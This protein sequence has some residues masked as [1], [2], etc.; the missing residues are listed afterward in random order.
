MSHENKAHYQ[1]EKEAIYLILI[2]IGDEIYSTVDACKTAQEMWKAIERLQQGN[3]VI[4]LRNV[5]CTQEEGIDYDEV[6][7][8]VARIKA[9]RLFLAYVSFMGF[10]V[11]QMDVKSAFLYGRIEE[12]VYVCQPLGFEDPD[13]PDKVYK[14]EKALYGKIDQT[15]FIKRQKEDILLVQVYV[16]D[17]IFGSTKKELCIEFEKL[18][19]DKF[20]MSSIGELTFFLRLQVKQESNGI[21]ISQDKYID[22]IL[23]KFKYTNVKPVSTLMDKEKALLKDSDG[24]DV[25]VHLYRR[26][27]TNMVEFDIGQEDDKVCSTQMVSFLKK[28]QGS[29]DFHQIVDFLKASHIRILDNEEIELNATVDGQAKTITKSSVKRHLKLADA[30]GISTL[31]TTEIFKQLALMGS[32][33]DPTLLNNSEMAA[34]EPGDLPVPDLRTIE[35]LCQPSLNGQGGTFMKRRLEECYDLIENMTAHHNDWD[36][37]AQRK[38]NINL[39]R[40]LQVNQQVKAITPNCKTFGGPHS[41]FDCPATVGNTQNVY[42]AGA[43][44][45]VTTN[46]FIN[47]MKANDAILKNMQT[48]MT[49]LKNSN[50]KLKNMFDQFMKMNTASSLGSGTLPGNTITNPKEDLKGI[51]TRSETAYQGPTTPTTTYFLVV[52]RETK[53]TK[54]TV[55]PTNNESTEDVQPS[56][57]PTESPILISEP[58]TSLIIEPVASP[59]S[60]LKHNLRPSIPYPSRLQD[61]KLYDKANDQREKFFQIFK[62]LNFNISFAGALILMP[63]FG[64]SIKSLLTNKD[65]LSLADL[66]ASINLMPFSIWNK[67]S[68]SDLSLTC[69]TLELTD[70]SISHPV[71]VFEDVFVK[72][73]LFVRPKGALIDVFKGELTLRVGKEAITFNLDQTSRYS[74]NYNNMTTNRIDVIDMACEE[75]SQEVLDFSDVIASGNPTPYY[76]SIVSTTSLTLTSFGNSD[77][78]LEEVD[79]FLAL[80]DDPTSPKVDQSYLDSE[81]DILNLEAFLNDDP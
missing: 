10:L 48:N 29:E 35:K 16:N 3:L 56:V 18:M 26:S 9:I 38:I 50:L 11:Y 33:T 69:M 22:E 52:E 64:P 12:E 23:R 4:L 68:L 60:V 17:I 65:K 67:L 40:V 74:A 6:F 73:D 8:P 58:V 71:G 43:Y 46:E 54:D 5:G 2:G 41:F 47:F 66:D 7:A 62:D 72:V 49:S 34:E 19:H 42:A 15:L 51:T 13:Y 27:T 21:F 28:P 20:Q 59:V 45:V 14:V 55:H 36:T 1:S 79:A 70:R 31:P 61:Q 25:D 80:E 57:V 44:Q 77:F 30:E 39:M 75:Y 76:D 53:A 63:Q 78:L 32:H 81:G 37:S 24:D